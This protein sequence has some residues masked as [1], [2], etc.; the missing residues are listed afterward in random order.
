MTDVAAPGPPHSRTTKKPQFVRGNLARWRL[1]LFT[2]E[3]SFLGLPFHKT[4]GLLALLSF[5]YRYF[6]C[7]PKTGGLGLGPDRFSLANMLVHV[8]LSS[9]SLIFRV[10]RN[11]VKGKPAMIWE[12]YRLHAVVFTLRCLIVY[13]LNAHFSPVSAP[14]R[15]AAVM[16]MHACADIITKKFGTPG[17]TTVRGK[18][19]V[20]H[21]LAKLLIPT[22][23]AYQMTALASHLTPNSS[24]D[25]GYNTLIAIQSSAFCMTLVRKS[26]F[27]LKAHALV[28]S[29]CLAISAAFIFFEQGSTEFLAGVVGAYV[30]RTKMRWNKYVIW[31]MFSAYIHNNGFALAKM[32]LANAAFTVGP[33]SA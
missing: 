33:L 1:K 19:Q 24:A 21:W 32:A 27:T 16:S 4:F 31:A 11:R 10:P 13:V 14:V 6:I 23:G 5:A 15:Y 26:L 18:G 17:D 20:D 30:L 28:Y 3:D 9:S 29:T 2:S 25:A 12:E 8:A 7:W 22:Y